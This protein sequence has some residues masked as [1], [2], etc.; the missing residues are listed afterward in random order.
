MKIDED[1]SLDIASLYFA[2]IEWASIKDLYR[3]TL[4]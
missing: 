3:R 1:N 2:A 4:K